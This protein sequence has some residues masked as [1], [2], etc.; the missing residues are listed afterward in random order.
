MGKRRTG[1]NVDGDE[2][3]EESRKAVPEGAV[4]D[5]ESAVEVKVIGQVLKRSGGKGKGERKH[6]QAF[7]VDGCR[8]DVVSSL[9]P[10]EDGRGKRRDSVMF[11]CSTLSIVILS[12]TATD[13]SASSSERMDPTDT[14]L[15]FHELHHLAGMT[16]LKQFSVYWT[17]SDL[18]NGSLVLPLVS[19]ICTRLRRVT[20]LF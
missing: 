7:E 8:Y 9:K 10:K 6:Y 4:S 2:E 12:D 20:T 5:E 17:P 13:F 19:Q 3:E 15:E 18:V 14:L 1:T 16:L 11:A